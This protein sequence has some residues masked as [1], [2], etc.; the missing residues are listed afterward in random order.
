M[1]IGSTIH[2]P[3]GILVNPNLIDTFELFFKNGYK[4]MTV[5]TNKEVIDLEKVRDVANG[6]DSFVTNN[7]FFI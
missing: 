7:F 3:N 1:E 5:N 4:A 6:R 2:Q